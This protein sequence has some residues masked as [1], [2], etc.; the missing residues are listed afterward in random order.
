LGL[1]AQHLHGMPDL[2]ALPPVMVDGVDI[3]SDEA[4]LEQHFR[5]LMWEHGPLLDEFLLAASP[6]ETLVYDVTLL[7][8]II[9]HFASDTA[10]VVELSQHPRDS[11][12]TRTALAVLEHE[13]SDDMS[14]VLP[15]ADLDGLSLCLSEPSNLQRFVPPQVL[16]REPLSGELLLAMTPEAR[17]NQASTSPNALSQS[18][19]RAGA[20]LAVQGATALTEAGVNAVLL[21]GVGMRASLGYDPLPLSMSPDHCVF[22][23]SSSDFERAAQVV[24]GE[25]P[26][27]KFG[28]DRV[29]ASGYSDRPASLD[30]QAVIENVA[31]S[32]MTMS[33]D[34]ETV[35]LSMTGIPEVPRLGVRLPTEPFSVGSRLRVLT[36][37]AAALV[38]V[39][40]K[41]LQRIHN[42][43]PYLSREARDATLSLYGSMREA[44]GRPPLPADTREAFTQLV[45]ELDVAEQSL[46]KTVGGSGAAEAAMLESS[47]PSPGSS[48][49]APTGRELPEMF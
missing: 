37:T 34:G 49:S 7:D 45:S 9:D 26:V 18:R 27:H 23:A 20:Y 11:F 28:T 2:E 1:I 29:V 6:L 14:D 10:L 42:G 19:V 17:M 22:V 8:R 33:F 24:F 5:K 44:G 38:L 4:A 48:G 39:A 47:P 16:R 31:R 21:G 3:S 13:R 41:S 12:F 25:E 35:R 32:E 15:R 40:S 30:T 46:S 36:P 43:E